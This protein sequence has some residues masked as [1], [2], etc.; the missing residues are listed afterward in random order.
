MSMNDQYGASP[1]RLGVRPSSEL[2]TARNNLVI[3]TLELRFTRAFPFSDPRAFSVDL[4]GLELVELERL[5]KSLRPGQWRPHSAYIGRA[6]ASLAWGDGA[7]SGSAETE[8]R[9]LSFSQ[10]DWSFRQNGKLSVQDVRW[11]G[12]GYKLKSYGLKLVLDPV[13][14]RGPHTHIDSWRLRLEAD[15]IAYAPVAERWTSDVVVAGEDARPVLSLLGVRDLPPR[16]S[17]FLA[18]PNV[19]VRGRLDLSPERQDV[20]VERG[21]SNTIDVRGRWIREG[22]QSHAALLFRAAPFSLG[23]EVQPG[24]TGVQLFASDAWLRERLERLPK[25]APAHPAA[26]GEK[27]SD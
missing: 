20:A 26:G 16:I 23:V 17:N 7:A 25:S 19:R 8:F 1:S 24:D 12:P 13:S 10:G 21:E 22:E 18:M 27:T 5:P 14:M 2:A 3:S 9:E 11:R 6:H 4:G 15:Q